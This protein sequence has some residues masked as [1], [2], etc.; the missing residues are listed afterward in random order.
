MV[1]VGCHSSIKPRRL[2]VNV[3]RPHKRGPA[4]PPRGAGAGGWRLRSPLMWLRWQVVTWVIV[5]PPH[6]HPA[7]RILEGIAA[8]WFL[9]GGGGEVEGGWSVGSPG[10]PVPHHGDMVPWG[11]V[12]WVLVPSQ[13]V[14]VGK[15]SHAGKPVA[16][17]PRSWGLL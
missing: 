11:P 2:V 15:L 14:M 4:K 7:F 6:C 1:T 8:G 5:P 17:P 16:P 3:N 10:T 12:L 13:P 9:L